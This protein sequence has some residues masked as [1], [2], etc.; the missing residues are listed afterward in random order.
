VVAQGAFLQE[1]KPKL[2]EVSSLK[3]LLY[4][5]AACTYVVVKQRFF[6]L[7]YWD[8]QQLYALQM[9]LSQLRQL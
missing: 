8:Y 2:I 3:R 1:L 4:L 7:E 9:A 5:L 6:R